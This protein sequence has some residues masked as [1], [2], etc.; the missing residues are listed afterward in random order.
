MLPGRSESSG[1][2]AAVLLLLLLLL[3]V[4]SPAVPAAADQ[5]AGIQW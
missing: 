1:L 3:L 5:W 4:L 2:R